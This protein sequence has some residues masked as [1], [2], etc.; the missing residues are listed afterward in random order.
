METV[1]LFV[2]SLK[3][4]GRLKDKEFVSGELSVVSDVF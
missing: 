4:F 1:W 3:E 2:F